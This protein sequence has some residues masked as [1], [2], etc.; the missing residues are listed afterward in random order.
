MFGC[1]SSTCRHHKPTRYDLIDLLNGRKD[2]AVHL[3]IS[4]PIAN[5]PINLINDIHCEF[6]ASEVIR[7]INYRIFGPESNKN[8]HLFLDGIVVQERCKES[9]FPHF[10]I[11]L[12]CPTGMAMETFRRRLERAARQFDNP[13]FKFDLVNSPIDFSLRPRYATCAGPGFVHVS[14]CH[15]NLSSYLTKDWGKGEFSGA[16]FAILT[17]RSINMH[18]DRINLDDHKNYEEGLKRANLPHINK[19]SSRTRSSIEKSVTRAACQLQP[20][21]PPSNRTVGS[22]I[23]KEWRLIKRG[24]Q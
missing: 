21:L 17:G 23:G 18:R 4:R 13:D 8:G 22:G 1:T 6:I 11:Q 14:D 24:Q 15:D 5:I 10:H 16:K 12:I 3:T 7:Y 2:D 20:S 19:N 9:F